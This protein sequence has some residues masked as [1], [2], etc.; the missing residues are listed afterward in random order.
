MKAR[1]A[2]SLASV[3]L[4][5]SSAAEDLGVTSSQR[6]REG[7]LCYLQATSVKI[8]LFSDTR[9]HMRAARGIGDHGIHHCPNLGATTL[10]FRRWKRGHTVQEGVGGGALPGQEW[11]ARKD[12]GALPAPRCLRAGL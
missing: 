12:P 1:R 6:A 7:T 9:I 10:P 4:G 2:E 8:K 3:G 11:L 5:Y